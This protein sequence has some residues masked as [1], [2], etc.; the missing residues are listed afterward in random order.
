[1]LR[2][3]AVGILT[4]ACAAP[5]V[6]AQTVDE[7][8]A[9]NIEAHG[10][11]AKLKA[12][13]SMKA[14]GKM[15]LGPGMQAPMVAYEKRPNDFRSDF[16]FQ[17]MTGVQAYDGHDAWQIMPFNGKKD[18]ELVSAEERD[19]M[20]DNADLDGPL[21]DYA[22]KGHK[23]EF[24]GKDKLEGTDVY[25]L[26]IT[27]KDGSIQTWYIDTDSNLEIRKDSER[28]VRGTPR[29]QTQVVGDYKV[30]DGMPVPFSMEMSDTDHPE[31][32]MKLTLEKVEFNVP[33]D[34]NMFKMPAKTDATTKGA[35]A[36]EPKPATPDQ[37][38]PADTPKS[39][40]PKR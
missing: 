23:V 36:A 40:T 18:P 11:A 31:Q 33:V 24:L 26:K 1:M 19:E 4:L 14:T 9:K 38:P 7:I 2:K 5:I 15:E 17:G 25:K 30:V 37:K 22:Q 27:L 10:G 32:K 6:G 34:G 20:A 16:T 13:Q 28:V 3:V 39:E 29:K 12:V 35:D 21:V 8:V